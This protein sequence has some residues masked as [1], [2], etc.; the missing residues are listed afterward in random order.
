MKISEFKCKLKQHILM[1]K[2]KFSAL[3]EAVCP[4]KVFCLVHWTL[5]LAWLF[6]RGL[7]TTLGL[8][9]LQVAFPS[10]LFSLKRR[11][12]LDFLPEELYVADCT[13]AGSW[14]M[15]EAHPCFYQLTHLITCPLNHHALWDASC[16]VGFQA[17]QTPQSLNLRKVLE[18]VPRKR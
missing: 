16:M 12:H 18:K 8:S 6:S 9:C 7:S 13:P 10:L 5:G 1:L 17:L 3:G 11:L 4:L 2:Q 15:Q 14:V